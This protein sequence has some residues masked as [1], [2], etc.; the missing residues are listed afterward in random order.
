LILSYSACKSTGRGTSFLHS[1]QQYSYLLLKLF[2]HPRPGRMGRS[3]PSD[4]GKPPDTPTMLEAA[5]KGAVGH[6]GE[7]AAEGTARVD[8]LL[9]AN[10]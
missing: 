4:R 10:Q 5:Q 3:T 8:D 6:A 1:S 2:N 7:R 9:S